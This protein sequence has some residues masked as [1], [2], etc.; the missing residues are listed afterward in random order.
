[1]RKFVLGCILAWLA[2]PVLAAPVG[3]LLPDTPGT[4][5]KKAEDLRNVLSSRGIESVVGTFDA[6]EKLAAPDTRVILGWSLEDLTPERCTALRKASERGIALIFQAKTARRKAPPE[7]V[8]A[9]FG[10]VPE[11]YRAD[12]GLGKGTVERYMFWRPADNF[13][14]KEHPPLYA[15]YSGEAFALA[16]SD[17][18]IAAVWVRRDRTTADGAAMTVKGRNILLGIYLFDLA[19]RNNRKEQNLAHALQILDKLL[20]F[21]GVHKPETAVKMRRYHEP[22]NLRPITP[23]FTAHRALWLWNSGYV[24]DVKERKMLLDFLA[25]RKINTLYLCTSSRLLFSPEN[26]PRLKEFIRLANGQGIR[27]E[28]LDGWKEAVLPAQ[29]DAF[30]ASLQRVLDYNRTA[31]PEERFSGF[32]SD[33]EP[34]LMKQY[35]ASPEMRRRMDHDFI[36]LHAKCRDMIRQSGERD[37]VFGLAANE[38]LPRDLKRPGRHIRWR[39]RTASKLEHLLDIFDYFA[40]MSYHDSASRTIAASQGYVDL[41]GAKGKKV[42]VGS[43]T[44]DIIPLSGSRSITFYEEGLDYMEQELEKIDR[45]YRKSPGYGGLAIHHYESYRRMTD[46]ARPIPQL[47]APALTTGKRYCADRKEQVVHGKRKWRGPADFSVCWQFGWTPEFLI[48]TADVTDDQLICGR[49]SGEDLWL[50]DHLELWF[51]RPGDG[52]SIQI[53]ISPSDGVANQVWFPREWDDAARRALGESVS[54]E[55][56]AS[57]A[58]YHITARIPASAF[59]LKQYAKG[60]TLRIL[61]EAGDSDP[62]ED[63][64]AMLSLAPHREREKPATYHELRLQ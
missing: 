21:S 10:A 4:A 17:A 2:V 42:Y 3:I 64:G 28:A 12:S 49:R 9:L 1:M 8:A 19:A 36:E 32:Q 37:F 57:S 27:V 22:L 55:R 16:P 45:H 61:A 46:G 6:W 14:G 58:G 52:K 50:D 23:A 15:V 11:G 40:V 34:V 38:H 62:G 54:V 30:L 60:M 56:R 47:A 44:L 51:Q 13:F 25:G 7:E 20:V 43:E 26:T 59:G 5:Q 53:G 41:A 18:G 31:A 29:H 24:L 33:I 48:V 63:A 35:H 39:G